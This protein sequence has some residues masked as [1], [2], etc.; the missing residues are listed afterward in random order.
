MHRPEHLSAAV[1]PALPA[2]QPQL[3]ALIRVR[4]TLSQGPATPERD[5][6]LAHTTRGSSPPGSY[7]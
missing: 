4:H 3:G 2:V 1:L 5:Q 6:A 7:C